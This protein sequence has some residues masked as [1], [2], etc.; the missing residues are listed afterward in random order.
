MHPLKSIACATVILA[1]LSAANHFLQ[2]P[3]GAFAAPRGAAGSVVAV[4]GGKVFLTSDGRSW[5][6]AG[7]AG[8]SADPY[9]P[10]PFPASSVAYYGD[11]C[12]IDVN[13]DGWACFDGTNWVN[14]GPPGGGPTPA[15]SKTWTQLKTNNR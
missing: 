14:I 8:W 7:A 5:L 9:P 15:S 11:A 10:L 6:Y 2:T 1:S 3:V 12:L 4:G 13:G